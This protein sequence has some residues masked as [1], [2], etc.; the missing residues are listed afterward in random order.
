LQKNRVGAGVSARRCRAIEPPMVRAT[1]DN[2]C[3]SHS[4]DKTLLK[5]KKKLLVL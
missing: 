3:N 4:G 1:E 2:G 5:K